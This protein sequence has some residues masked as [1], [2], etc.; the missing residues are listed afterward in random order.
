LSKPRTPNDL[1]I[2]DEQFGR[3]IDGKAAFYVFGYI[4]YTDVFNK[5]RWTTYVFLQRA[6]DGM[7]QAL[8]PAEIGNE[9]EE[10]NE[11]EA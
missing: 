3:A 4:S 10:W 9:T 5:E 8:S 7:L 2:S 6:K 1:P 11:E